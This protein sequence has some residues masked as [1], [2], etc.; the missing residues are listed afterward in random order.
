[1]ATQ[2]Y[3][4]GSYNFEDIAESLSWDYSVAAP[5]YAL[6]RDDGSKPGGATVTSKSFKLEG[7][8]SASDYSSWRTAKDALMRGMFPTP[9]LAALTM[10]DDRQYLAEVVSFSISEWI[11][12]PQCPFSVTFLCHDP[13][14]YSDTVSANNWT[15]V[16]TAAWTSYIDAKQHAAFYVDNPGMGTRPMILIGSAVITQPIILS[17]RWGNFLLGGGFDTDTNGDGVADNWTKAGSGTASMSRSDYQGGS[18]AQKLMNGSVTTST[19]S[20][21]IPIGGAN[22][23]AGQQITASVYLK[24]TAGSSGNVQQSIIEYDAAGSVLATT[25]GTAYTGD[26]AWT[27]DTV[28]VTLNAGT[29]YLKHVLTNASDATAIFDS[30]MVEVAATASVYTDGLSRDLNLTLSLGAGDTFA[31][32][33][34]ARTVMLGATNELSYMSGE[35]YTLEYGA[36]LVYLTHESPAASGAAFGVAFIPRYL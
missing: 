5:T 8:F 10:S 22:G 2:Q 28:T 19:I 18:A 13:Y 11:G 29:V 27:R 25:N 32:D 9:R 21:M 26:V 17:H 33:H 30:A 7:Y 12:L 6:A 23:L 4:F 16:A 1:M 35:F 36:N 34:Y 15:S 24:R 3:K 20:Q 14:E 31:I